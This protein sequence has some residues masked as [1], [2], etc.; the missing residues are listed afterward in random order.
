MRISRRRVSICGDHP[1]QLFD[2]PKYEMVC[3]KVQRIDI[4]PS[5]IRTSSVLCGPEVEQQPRLQAGTNGKYKLANKV[6]TQHRDKTCCDCLCACLFRGKR[7]RVLIS[8]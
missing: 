8:V 6:H 4:F 2:A 1:I 7:T 3:H 5:A